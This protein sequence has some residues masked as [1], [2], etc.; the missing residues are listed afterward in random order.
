[1]AVA[2]VARGNLTKYRDYMVHPSRCGLITFILDGSV[3]VAS[4]EVSVYKVY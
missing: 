1:M 2:V 3:E 4:I